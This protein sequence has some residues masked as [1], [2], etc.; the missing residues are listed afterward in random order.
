MPV[1]LRFYTNKDSKKFA[2]M[3][4]NVPHLDAVIHFGLHD[5]HNKELIRETLL[6]RTGPDE[7][8][9]LLDWQRDRLMH[10]IKVAGKKPRELTLA[11]VARAME[12]T[13]VAP[14]S[15]GV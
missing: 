15:V 8:T 14:G 2:K 9:E 10:W 1:T 3:K 5:Q 6:V 13:I 4:A 11:D 12:S 7:Y